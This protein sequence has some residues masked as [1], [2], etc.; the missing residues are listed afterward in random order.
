MILDITMI[1]VLKACV[2]KS[3]GKEDQDILKSKEIVDDHGLILVDKKRDAKHI[4]EEKGQK[5]PRSNS[6]AS[7]SHTKSGG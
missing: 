5:G 7:T 1:H 3:S 4:K 2:R 6:G